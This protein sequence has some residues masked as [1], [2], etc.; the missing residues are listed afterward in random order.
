MIKYI[1]KRL[2]WLIP[3]IIIVS[4]IIFVL[5]DL[6]PG[7]VVDSMISGDMTQEEIDQ[8][9]HEYNLDRSVFYRYGVYMVNLLQGDLGTS[10]YSK[11]SVW[12]EFFSRFP[13]TLILSVA[14]LFIAIIISIPLGIYAAKHAGGIGDNLTTT[15]T[16]L[17]MSMPN[18]WL[19]LLLM[20]VFSYKLGWLPAGGADT[21]SAFILPAISSSFAMM[22]TSTRQTRSSMLDNIRADYLRTAR[23]KGV[24]ERKVTY[25]H[26]LR[27]A[28]IPV[29]TTMGGTFSRTLAGSAVIEAVFSFPGI[30]KLTV[31]AVTRRDATQVCG[32]V[33]LT[34]IMYVI[35]LLIVD[36]LYAFVDPRI[37]SLYTAGAKRPGKG[38]VKV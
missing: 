31:D 35:L 1:I 8:L 20:I 14:A 25:H 19:G 5:I 23:A 24:S 26:A 13:N 32:C 28:L 4:F 37:K 12:S 21:V 16:L 34:S 29:I 11:L 3:T 9:Y 33:I 36:L 27:N 18:F 6:A 38:K 17:G 10:E 15:F 22:A 2:L 7:T 30:G